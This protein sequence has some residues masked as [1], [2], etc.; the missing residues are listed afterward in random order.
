[1]SAALAALVAQTAKQPL[2]GRMRDLFIVLVVV[3]V[4]SFVA[5][6]LT[7]PHALWAAWRNRGRAQSARPAGLA[8]PDPADWIAG[9]DETEDH[10]LLFTLSLGTGLRILA[11]SWP[12][13]RNG[14][15]SL[16]PLE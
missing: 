2:H 4:V 9:C 1:M 12:S 15:R 14:A 3:A 6:L 7:G 8:K 5:L 10:F 11:R 13:A 16:I